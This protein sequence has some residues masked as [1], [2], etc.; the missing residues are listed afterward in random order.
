MKFPWKWIIFGICIL[1][2]LSAIAYGGTGYKVVKE[3]L[4]ADQMQ[5]QQDLEKEVT[6][7]D[8]ERDQ[9]IKQVAQLKQEKS[10]L[11]Q[12]YKILEGRYANLEN[13]FANIIVPTNPDDLVLAFRKGGFSSATRTSD[14]RICF[15]T[16]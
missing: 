6:R 7:L 14:G 15:T 1:I 2:V 13:Q 16:K 9:Y 5:I 3:W 4:I 12:Q 11:N 10:L 8:G